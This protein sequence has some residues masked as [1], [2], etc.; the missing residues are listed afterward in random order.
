M[1]IAVCVKHAVD[2]TELKIDPGGKPVLAGAVSR[3]STF[4]KNAVEEGLRLK[5][6]HQGEVT[7]FT[8]GPVESK[9]TMKEALAMGADR[10]VLVTADTA[11]VDTMRTA[12]LLAAALKKA[13]PFDLVLC[14]EGS[15]DTYSGQVPPMLAELLGAAFVGYARKLEIDGQAARAERSLEDSVE[16]VEAPFPL[17]ASVVSEIN[18]PRYPTLI[19]IMQAGKK[20]LEELNG[21][22]LLSPPG[23]R[24]A[25]VVSM[26]AQQSARKRLIIE[27]SPDEAA[28]RLVDALTKEGVLAK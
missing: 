19:Q 12:G 7:V 3:M 18:E 28:A 6:A 27:G 4:D 8:V 25:T 11:A 1:K 15:S 2:E 10:G 23:H 24:Q 13:G 5:A 21:D 14:S 20:P 26:A 16:K 17:V 9:K 22:Q